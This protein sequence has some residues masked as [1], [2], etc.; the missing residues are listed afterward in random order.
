MDDLRNKKYDDWWF[1]LS[2]RKG[3]TCKKPDVVPLREWMASKKISR[4]HHQ[5]GLRHSAGAVPTKTR[6]KGWGGQLETSCEFCGKEDDTEQRLW[7]CSLTKDLRE[8]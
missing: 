4:R 7:H 1:E 8:N 3:L 5:A 6:L 2:I